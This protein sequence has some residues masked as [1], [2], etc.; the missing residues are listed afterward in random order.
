[1][2]GREWCAEKDD[3]YVEDWR[4]Q[5]EG[6]DEGEEGGLCRRSVQGLKTPNHIIIHIPLSSYPDLAPAY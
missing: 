1:M 4:C 5:G 6:E 2:V 3:E